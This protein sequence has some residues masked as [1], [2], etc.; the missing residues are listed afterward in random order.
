[1][2][3]R[4]R[5][6]FPQQP[7]GADLADDARETHEEPR[8][9]LDR[10]HRLDAVDD[11]T[12]SRSAEKVTRTGPRGFLDENRARIQRGA[13][14]RLAR[15]LGEGRVRRGHQSERDERGAFQ[16][17]SPRRRSRCRKNRISGP[18]PVFLRRHFDEIDA[19]S[20][21]QPPAFGARRPSHRGETLRAPPCS[22]IDERS[23]PVSRS[24]RRT[25]PTSGRRSHA[26][27]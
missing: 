24:R 2:V 6:L 18:D 20:A 5:L 4:P 19:E 3:K 1:M 23:S 21:E 13:V 25:K 27:R 15:H 7:E 14:S 9:R 22:R 10:K 11:G 8:R 12:S 26:D 16:R 17:P